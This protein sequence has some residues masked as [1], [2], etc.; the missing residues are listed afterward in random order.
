MGRAAF[1]V[2]C[3]GWELFGVMLHIT[4]LV[5]M[6]GSEPIPKAGH[7]D[8]L[9]ASS[10]VSVANLASFSRLFMSSSHR[11]GKIYLH[12]NTAFKSCK[13]HGAINP[14]F[15]WTLPHKNLCVCVPTWVCNL[16]VWTS[17]FCIL[18][19][20]DFQRRESQRLEQWKVCFSLSAQESARTCLKLAGIVRGPGAG[21]LG[22]SHVNGAHT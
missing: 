3:L 9:S 20:F 5:F 17:V 8:S 1:L 7:A 15:G 4:V 12:Y 14:A 16:W 6:P 21:L 22:T 19:A 10:S 13:L 2:R 11:E 18:Q